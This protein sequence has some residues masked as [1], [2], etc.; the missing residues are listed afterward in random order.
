MGTSG[1]ISSTTDAT[2]LRLNRRPYFRN[3]TVSS[4]PNAGELTVFPNPGVGIVRT[5]AVRISPGMDRQQVGRHSCGNMHWA[6]L[7]AHDK[8]RDPDKPDQL[9]QRSLPGQINAI[10]RCVNSAVR[11]S[12]NHHASWRERAA[13]FLDYACLKAICPARGR[14]DEEERTAG[15]HRSAEVDRHLEL[16][17]EATRQSWHR[18]IPPALDS[19]Q[20]DD[21]GDRLA[22][23][24]RRTSLLRRLHCSSRRL[25]LRR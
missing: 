20:Q 25:L 8:S 5:D 15:A 21:C 1:R 18:R 11:L 13:K 4:S 19:A 2:S 6:A 3:L 12:D 16:S 24:S 9:K 22:L 17:I 23:R 7:H 10:F 14:K